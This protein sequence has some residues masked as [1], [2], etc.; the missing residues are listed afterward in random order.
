MRLLLLLQWVL[1]VVFVW[2]VVN[3]L[4]YLLFKRHGTRGGVVFWLSDKW[5]DKD[6][7]KEGGR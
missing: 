2:L 7:G 4:R 3:I 1:I 5:M 6:K